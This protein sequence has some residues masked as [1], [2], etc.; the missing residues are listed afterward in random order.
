DGY[1]ARVVCDRGDFAEY[2]AL[3]EGAHRIREE[4]RRANTRGRSEAARRALATLR[5]GDVIF[6][7]S[8]RRRGLAVVISS[9]EGR[10]TVLTQDRRYFRLVLDDFDAAPRA[11]ARID[12]P[13]SGSARSARVRRDL[14][15]K[16]ATLRVRPPR[17]RRASF[18][19]TAEKRAAE[20]EHEAAQH[21]CHACPDRSEHERWAARAS[22]LEKDAAALERRIRSRTE[23]LGRQF[24]RV[25]GVLEDLGY[26]RGFTLTEKGDRL[27]RIYG[28]GD[29]LVI[30]ALTDR[31]LDGLPPS[32]FSALVSTLVYESRERT[33]SRPDIPTRTLRTGYSRLMDL[34]RQVRRAEDARQVELCRELDPGFVPTIFE[35]AEGKPLD[36]LLAASGLPAGDFVRNC[37]Q[38]LDLL[39]QIQEVAEPDVAPVARAAY[40]SINRSVVSYTG[41]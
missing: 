6:L 15:A 8:A 4:A 40:D 34:W 25:L 7:P 24:D 28:E 41:V 23:T 3:R 32:E 16:L 38:L 20:I 13:R 27:R 5:P 18:D 33:P 37:K 39:R 30:E 9:R 36:D 14:A 19:P 26:V 11:V 21:P 1:R 17:Q 35:W 2:W 22:K 31:L 10:P 12:L 29:I